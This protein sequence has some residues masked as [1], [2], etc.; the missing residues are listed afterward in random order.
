MLSTKRRTLGQVLVCVGCCCGRV[1]RGHPPVPVEWL[2]HA[3]KTRRLAT[4]I[5]L[6][7]SGCLGPCDLVNVVGLVHPNGTLWLGGLET[8]TH[9]EA[10]VEWATESAAEGRLLP[11]PDSLTPLRFER[12][13]AP[14]PGFDQQTQPLRPL[15]PPLGEMGLQGQED[16]VRLSSQFPKL[17]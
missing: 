1:D 12:F 17:A 2:K 3:W 6:T 16:E 14:S 11:L 7:I 8:Q 9:Y 4:S 10:I 15:S 5:Q 13:S